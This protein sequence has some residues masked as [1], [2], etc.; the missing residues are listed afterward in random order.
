MLSI[1]RLRIG[2]IQFNISLGEA[3][4]NINTAE[5]LLNNMH[6]TDL[7]VLPE[8][9]YT[10]FDYKN[11]KEHAKKKDCFIDVVRVW[12]KRFNTSFLS[13]FLI[14]DEEKEGVYNTL[15][16]IDENGNICNK[17]SKMY[18]FGPMMEDKY[19]LRGDKKQNNIFSFKGWKIATAICYEVRF[20]EIMR[21]AALNGAEL[22][23]IPTEWPDVRLDHWL[24]LTKARAIENEMYL[25]GINACR[26]TGKWNMAG[27]SVI[28]D[29]WGNV[30]SLLSDKEGI[31]FAE[32]D[33]KKIK[34]MKE[35]IPSVNDASKFK[36]FLN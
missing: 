10:G 26:K 30:I 8:L 6:K 3:K 28:Y 27:H 36:F 15:Y 2:G 22:G 21:K 4:K 7:I 12:C 29:P 1:N 18:L 16:L 14:W 20:P 25:M 34:Q 35:N 9:W 31:I 19:F 32:I 11:L 5:R 24:S 17:Y 13:T 33:K 23:I